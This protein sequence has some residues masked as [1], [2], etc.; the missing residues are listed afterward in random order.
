LDTGEEDH[1][2]RK[3]GPDGREEGLS[4][5][6]WNCKRSGLVKKPPEVELERNQG[7]GKNGT[8]FFT[9]QGGE[10]PKF[11]ALTGKGKGKNVV[12]I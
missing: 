9:N 3:R 7:E 1:P 2:K 5:F 6:I 11:G 10:V 4:F 12:V 8:C